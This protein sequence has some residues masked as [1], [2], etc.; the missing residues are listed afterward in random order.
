MISREG[1]G[2][3]SGLVTALTAA[4]L[5]TAEEEAAQRPDG[6]CDPPVLGVLDEAANVCRWRELPDLYSHF[7]SRGIILMSIFQ[8]WAQMESAF[9]KEGAEKLW[10]AANVRAY[11]GGVSDTTF[12]KRLSDLSGHY[13]HRTNSSSDSRQGLSRSRSQQRREQLT[14]AE[15]GAMP[16]GR[17][18]VLLSAASPVIV[19]TT[20]FD[21][22][23]LKSLD[24]SHTEAIPTEQQVGI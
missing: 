12:L 21:D 7:G 15:L 2:S 9:G 10:S 6:R 16:P 18:L 17:A 3:A 20:P 23:D 19:E 8:S 1:D 24:A 14:T 5:R 4:V 22:G 13:E 11:L